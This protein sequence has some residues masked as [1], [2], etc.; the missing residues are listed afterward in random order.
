MTD[1]LPPLAATELSNPQIRH[2]HPASDVDS[3][4]IKAC[5]ISLATPN[6]V[7]LTDLTMDPAAA[8]VPHLESAFAHAFPDVPA[9]LG[10]LDPDLDSVTPYQQV[11]PDLA[12]ASLLSSASP[13]ETQ[14][15]SMAAALAARQGLR[16]PSFEAL[17][18]AAPHPD[19]KPTSGENLVIGAGPLSKPGDPLHLLSPC[20][21]SSATVEGP[22]PRRDSPPLPSADATTRSITHYVSTLTPPD[23]TVRPKWPESYPN[24]TSAAME[25]PAHSNP[26]Q[27]T[28]NV[29]HVGGTGTSSSSQNPPNTISPGFE[30]LES[31]IG[32]RWLDSAVQTLRMSCSRYASFCKLTSKSE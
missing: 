21:L 17:G 22:L 16:L 11:Q 3:L 1:P 32:G 7:E 29:G 5:D 27:N 6:D 23:E 25:S 18:I 10:A 26:E 12:F 4:R 13:P 20:E 2:Q 15:T 28:P 24:V 19:R 31:G 8:G 30:A 14:Q 9:L